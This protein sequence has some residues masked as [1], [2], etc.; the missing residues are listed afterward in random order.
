MPLRLGV[1]EPEVLVVDGS[2]VCS[3]CTWKWALCSSNKYI[4]QTL[5]KS[6]MLLFWLEHLEIYY[7]I[8]FVVV[9]VQRKY[10]KVAQ[11]FWALFTV[12]HIV[13]S[14]FQLVRIFLLFSVHTLQY[15]TNTLLLLVWLILIIIDMLKMIPM[16]IKFTSGSCTTLGNFPRRNFWDQ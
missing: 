2:S 8:F 1:V 12:T 6:L 9:F 4:K 10:S 15:I 5:R 11:L 14:N 16:N 3:C 13:L 7:P